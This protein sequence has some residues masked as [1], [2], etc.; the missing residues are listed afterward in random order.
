MSTVALARKRFPFSLLSII[1]KEI[2]SNIVS[3]DFVWNI[4][5]VYAFSKIYVEK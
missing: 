2:N 4:C 1:N 3:E 5:L